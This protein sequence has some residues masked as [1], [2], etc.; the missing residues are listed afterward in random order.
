[1]DQSI[2][3]DKGL[4]T[5]TYARNGTEIVGKAKCRPSDTFIKEVGLA[6]AHKK[7]YDTVTEN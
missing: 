2:D 3:R 1:M 6:I 4:V 7:V 5:V